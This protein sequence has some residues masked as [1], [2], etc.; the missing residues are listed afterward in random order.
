[1]PNDFAAIVKEAA[2]REKEK[3]EGGPSP[4][5]SP[6]NK[7][8]QQAE[9]SAHGSADSSQ[10]VN[11]RHSSLYLNGHRPVDSPDQLSL[12]DADDH[13]AVPSSDKGK[14]RDGQGKRGASHST[15][16]GAEGEDKQAK[17]TEGGEADNSAMK[18]PFALQE[19]EKAD[20]RPKSRSK[21]SSKSSKAERPALGGTRASSMFHTL[22][23]RMHGRMHDDP[24]SEEEHE[25][26]ERDGNRPE[27]QRSPSKQQSGEVDEKRKD[28]GPGSKWTALRHKI[29]GDGDGVK[30]SESFN[31]GLSGSEL[32]RELGT[33][34]LPTI[35]I[36]M[37][38]M[39]RDECVGGL[40]LKGLLN[41]QT[42]TGMDSIAYP[43]A[44]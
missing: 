27:T 13:P 31:K 11:K 8:Q 3:E 29:R 7:Q 42:R 1:M 36:K 25:G 14:Q 38:L 2:R 19:K 21:D 23:Q 32:V 33:G 4:P 22:T 37:S 17:P 40:L 5:A 9:R 30:P 10:A 35:M 18:G 41:R 26:E 44:S 39:D 34:L 15:A 28:S 6:S 43:C 12:A 16:G 24:L 20:K